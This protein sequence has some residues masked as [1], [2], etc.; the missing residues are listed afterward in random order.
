MRSHEGGWSK[1]LDNLG[2]TLE[3]AAPGRVASRAQMPEALDRTG[4]EPAFEEDFSGPELDPGRWVAH[5]LPQWT[6]P[7]RSAARFELTPGGLRL[8][9]DADQPA[10]R[11]EDG[12]MRVSNLQTGTFSGPPACPSDSTATGPASSSRRRSPRAACTRRRAASPKPY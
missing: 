7:E 8:R 6:T 5:Y 9:I 4:Y 3:A 1:V 10:W 11:V 2:R 12:G